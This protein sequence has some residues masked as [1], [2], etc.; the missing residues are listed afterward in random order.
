MSSHARKLHNHTGKDNSLDTSEVGATHAIVLKLLEG[1]EGRGHHVYTDNYYS[2]PALFGD[3]QRRGFGA[4][5]TVRKNRRGLPKE[6]SAK[7]KKG[8]VVSK[9]VDGSMMALKWMDKR[10]VMMLSTIHDDS[11]VTKK[12]RSRAAPG[13]EE[14]IL[15]PLVVEEYNKNMGGVD[16]GDQL[17]SYYGFSHRTLKWWR[18]LFFH[19]I[20]LA[21]VNAYI[22]Y[23]LSPCS[24][25]RLTHA[26]FRIE[27]AKQLLMETVEE[28]TAEQQR[29]PHSNPNPPS[30][31]LTGRHFPGKVS[32]TA[33]GRQ[34]RPDCVVCSR[35]KGR[36]RVS[37]T[38]KCKQCHLPMCVVPCFELY[39]TK[40]NPER[41]L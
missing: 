38:Y 10:P 6:M 11:F 19:L 3:L 30:S 22:L 17:L 39:H 20:D 32:P 36:G 31:R 5:G 7:L 2:S 26:Q 8:E 18:R 35:K 33:S 21:I 4:C 37:T 14:D 28:S 25:R 27:L 16:T 1:R 13:G 41:Y 34:S 24:G 12:R 29:G 40:N 9:Q 23:L 15:K